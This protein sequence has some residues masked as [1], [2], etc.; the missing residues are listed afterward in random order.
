MNLLGVHCLA[1]GR[2]QM[3]RI[4][5]FFG[6]CSTSALPRPLQ[7]VPPLHGIL[8]RPRPCLHCAFC[9]RLLL[10]SAAEQHPVAVPLPSPLPSPFHASSQIASQSLP[11][12][13]LDGIPCSSLGK[14]VSTPALVLNVRRIRS[15]SVAC[16]TSKLRRDARRV[17]IGDGIMNTPQIVVRLRLHKPI[18]VRY[19]TLVG[20]HRIKTAPIAHPTQPTDYWWP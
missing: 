7:T 6:L 14:D 20:R 18:V 8:G 11:P 10:V 9:G 13:C 15:R 2:A 16:S 1:Q 19:S 17:L 12:Y 5:L 4:R 3:A